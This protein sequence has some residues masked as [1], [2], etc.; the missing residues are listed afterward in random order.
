MRRIVQ[1]GTGRRT[2]IQFKEDDVFLGCEPMYLEMKEL[3]GIDVA[4]DFVEYYIYEGLIGRNKIKGTAKYAYPKDDYEKGFILDSGKRPP[5]VYTVVEKP[6]IT[7][8]ELLQKYEA[9]GFME[10]IYFFN[11]S[12]SGVGQYDIFAEYSWRVKPKIF[13]TVTCE[14]ENLLPIFEKQGYDVLKDH[15]PFLAVLRGSDI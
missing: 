14:A 5:S 3:Y 10:S 15:N 7:L 2:W 11:V 6:C 9:Q 13:T 1:I 8:D 4:P 12:F